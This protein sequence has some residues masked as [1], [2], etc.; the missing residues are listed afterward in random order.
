[1][2]I[3]TPEKE[4]AEHGLAPDAMGERVALADLARQASRWAAQQYSKELIKGPPLI[5][6][7]P[8]PPTSLS[9]A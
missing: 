7:P 2:Q 1:M 8:P 5:K 9:A 6:R 4:A 3:R